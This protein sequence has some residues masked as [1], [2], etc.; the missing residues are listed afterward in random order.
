MEK[1]Y[2]KVIITNSDDLYCS[3]FL[4]I[5]W[6]GDNCILFDDK[7]HSNYR[8]DIFAYKSIGKS[9]CDAY[10]YP[11]SKNLFLRGLNIHSHMVYLILGFS[12]IFLVIS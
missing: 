5:T 6:L 8:H 4:F 7:N 11:L 12:N 9:S 3:I 2:Y 1:L 10:E